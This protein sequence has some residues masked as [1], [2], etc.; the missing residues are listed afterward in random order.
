LSRRFR[1]TE[2]GRYEPDQERAL[3]RA[4]TPERVREAAHQLLPRNARTVVSLS[5]SARAPY[6][7]RVVTDIVVDR[8]ATATGGGS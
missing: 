8:E 7:G 5:A 3:H 4:L 6:A 2:D 1:E